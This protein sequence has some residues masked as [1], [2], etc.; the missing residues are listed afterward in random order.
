MKKIWIVMVITL[1]VCG[2][3]A[4]KVQTNTQK[5][6]N[7]S[8]SGVWVSYSELNKMLTSEKGFKS[9]FED[10]LSNL[11]KMK[12]QNLYIHVRAFCDSLYKSEYFPLMQAVNGYE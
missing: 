11:K 4:P 1:L 10:V 6:S 3:S 2:C 7:S 5:Y 12:I 9:E 8:E